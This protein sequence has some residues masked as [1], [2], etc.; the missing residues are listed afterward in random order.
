[1]TQLKVSP[2]LKLN[3]RFRRAAR[4]SALKPAIL[5]DESLIE[6]FNVRHSLK[7]IK[8]FHRV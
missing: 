7:S 2:K 8:Q 4:R 5:N 6:V 3:G 1:M